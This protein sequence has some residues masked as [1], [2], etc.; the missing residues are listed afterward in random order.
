MQCASVGAAVKTDRNMMSVIGKIYYVQYKAGPT[1]NAW[2]DTVVYI[3]VSVSNF[4]TKI[5]PLQPKPPSI[6]VENKTKKCKD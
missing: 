5:K 6:T 1:R 4:P 2:M 3:Y